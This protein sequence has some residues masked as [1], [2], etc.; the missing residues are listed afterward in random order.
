MSKGEKV[1]CEKRTYSH[2]FDSHQHVYGQLLFPLQGSLE[3]QT[4]RRDLQLNPDYCFY[5]PP[6]CYHTFRSSERNS[7]L[8][9]D[10]PKSYLPHHSKGMYVNLDGQWSAIRYLLMEEAKEQKGSSVA[11][12]ELAR[13]VSQKLGQSTYPSIEYIHNHFN[14]AITIEQLAKLEHYHPVYYSS[15]FEQ[16]TGKSPKQYISDI[17]LQEA[18]RLLRETTWSVTF[19]SHECGFSS[20]P[21]FTRWFVRLEGISPSTYRKTLN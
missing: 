19:I 1:V 16:V 8:V 12:N 9:L 17:R 20:L 13:Y 11:L 5:L 18:K 14:E 21:S 7:F 6:E 4:L 15:W 2:E 10:M 3:I